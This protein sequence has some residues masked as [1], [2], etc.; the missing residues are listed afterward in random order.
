MANPV[1]HEPH[2]LLIDPLQLEEAGR[3]FRH[4]LDRLLGHA[5]PE[6]DT[7]I[8]WEDGEPRDDQRDGVQLGH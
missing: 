8:P 1:H 3:A 2:R 7:E 5:V 4:W 6:E